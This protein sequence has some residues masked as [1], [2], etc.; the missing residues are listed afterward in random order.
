MRGLRKCFY[1]TV[2][3]VRNHK[4]YRYLIYQFSRTP[5]A[6]GD[7]WISELGF[8]GLD[9]NG[10]EVKLSGAPI[11][12]PGEY[13][14]LIGKLFDSIQY[15]VFKPD[16]K[17]KE[18]YAGIDLGKG[19]E[20]VV[21]KIKFMPLT[22]DNAVNDR[23]TYELFY[24]EENRWSSV[25]VNK[26]GSGVKYVTF[27]NVPGN[28]LLLLKNTSGGKQQRIFVYKEGRQIFW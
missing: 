7:G 22:D 11:G 2:I 24:W 9:K 14:H 21:T 1:E 3:P 6:W 26:A 10:K 4:R 28:A 18:R 15:N 5:A 20:A 13:P 12:N 16:M 23:D 27:E 17:K 8:Y 19:N 25:G